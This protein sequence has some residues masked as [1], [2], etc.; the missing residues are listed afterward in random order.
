ML[1]TDITF[2]LE[3][4]M[5]DNLVGDGVSARMQTKILE[6]LPTVAN[7]IA[8][9]DALQALNSLK[10]PAWAKLPDRD[11]IHKLVVFVDLIE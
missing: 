10:V 4:S 3:V 5:V 6:C 9:T 11:S 2:D 7:H 1:L 8:P